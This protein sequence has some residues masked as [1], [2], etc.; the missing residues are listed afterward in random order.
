MNDR[1]CVLDTNLL[2][3]STVIDNPWHD[4]SRR[5][6]TGL[7]D[8]RNTLCITTQ[9]LREYLVVL[10]RGTVFE[11]AFSPQEALQALKGFLPSLHVLGQPEDSVPILI[12][13]I[14]RYQVK[15]KHIHDANVVAVMLTHNILRLVTFNQKDFKHFEEISL[16]PIP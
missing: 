7:Q 13:L 6:L 2:V 10:T 3:Y 11:T 9:I 5:W 14:S 1:R 4:Q 16:E 15:G 12:D 8:K